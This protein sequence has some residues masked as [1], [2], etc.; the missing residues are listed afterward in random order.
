MVNSADPTGVTGSVFFKVKIDQ[1]EL[2]SFVSCSGL[3]FEVKIEKREE[4]GNQGFVHQLPG[5]ISY[6]NVK[7]TRPL[8]A[9]SAKIAKWFSDMAGQVKR[10]TAE[11]TALTPNGQELTTWKLA[12][13]IPVRWSAPD[14]ST[15][16]AKAALETFEIAHHGFLPG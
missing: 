14:F 2:G 12:G 6:S 3:A 11:I 10:T 5:G 9:D 7:F 15:D 1:H 4:G 16:S 8:N 13:V